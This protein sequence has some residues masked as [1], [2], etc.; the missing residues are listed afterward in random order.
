M[1]TR[2]FMDLPLEII[3]HIAFM[4]SLAETIEMSLCSRPLLFAL[5]DDFLFR[6]PD[7]HKK[8][9][10]LIFSGV[11]DGVLEYL[12]RDKPHPGY[13]ISFCERAASFLTDVSIGISGAFM[14]FPVQS[15]QIS[16]YQRSRE[17][18]EDRKVKYDRGYHRAH[19]L[20]HIINNQAISL[21]LRLFA[22]YTFLHEKNGVVLKQRITTALTRRTND[23]AFTYLEHFMD[24]KFGGALPAMS[25]ALLT[26][27]HTNSYDE[28]ASFNSY[29]L[30]VKKSWKIFLEN[31]QSKM[32]ARCAKNQVAK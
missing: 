15:M 30:Q 8:I 11:K 25:D 16:S 10:H 6:R 3:Q 23:K 12:R 32:T 17:E 28:Y 9:Q 18:D 29:R 5:G 22:I 13:V 24:D 4:T 31:L 26:E 20:L 7:Y 19:C 14:L 27:V 2:E 21:E 1:L